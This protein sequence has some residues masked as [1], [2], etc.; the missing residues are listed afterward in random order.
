MKPL[1]SAFQIRFRASAVI[2]S[3]L[4]FTLLSIQDVGSWIALSK[5][6]YKVKHNLIAQ[7]GLRVDSDVIVNGVV[8][9][10]PVS[11][12]SCNASRRGALRWNDKFFEGCDG[13]HGWRPVYFCS[14]SCDIDNNTVPCG[15]PVRNKCEDLCQQTGSGLNM[16]QCLL[17]VATTPCNAPVLDLCGNPC[18]LA[19]Q[20]ACDALPSPYGA[21]LIKSLDAVNSTAAFQLTV[22]RMDPSTGATLSPGALRLSYKDIGEAEE[23]LLHIAREAGAAPG[24]RLSHPTPDAVLRVST[25]SELSGRL[26]HL[27]RPPSG[28]AA[29]VP[30]HLYIDG[31]IDQECPFIFSGA[32]DAPAAGLRV[33]LESPATADRLLSLPDASGLAVTSGSR[34]AVGSLPGLRGDGD[35]LVY[36]GA[37]KDWGG[38][39]P[40]PPPR[41][42]C[43]QAPPA[44]AGGWCGL[45]PVLTGEGLNVT[46]CSSVDMVGARAGPSRP[47]ALTGTVPPPPLRPGIR[48]PFPAPRPLFTQRRERSYSCRDV[49]GATV[50]ET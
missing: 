40:P 19:G 18:G 39:V 29:P 3:V 1:C 32:A 10:R 36:T 43:G 50:A 26:V 17:R 48:L 46:N 21:L 15:L 4:L 41:V 35:V 5:D 33:C 12:L 20:F 2:R 14:R 24:A 27:G 9:S 37:A 42:S 11:D 31:V 34:E 38:L 47:D 16:R 22:G 13:Q 28:A 45:G 30:S 23:D 6:G 25:L 8:I 7:A 49:K 44:G